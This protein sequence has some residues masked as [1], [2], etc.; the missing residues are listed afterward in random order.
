M[1]ITGISATHWRFII[2]AAKVILDHAFVKQSAIYIVANSIW[3]VP[4]YLCSCW[5]RPTGTLLRRLKM[6]KINNC[7]EVY[8]THP[9]TPTHTHT[10]TLISNIILPSVQRTPIK[11][12]ASRHLGTAEF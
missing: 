9:P 6:I 5:F 11:H 8:D 4:I 12:K 10:H 3:N 2:E 7:S 1:H